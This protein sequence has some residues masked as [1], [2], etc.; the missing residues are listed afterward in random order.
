MKVGQEV[1]GLK[2]KPG[3]VLRYS[4]K[5]LEFSISGHKREGCHL[6]QFSPLFQCQ[7]SRVT[8]NVKQLC[9]CIQG[10]ESFG[11]QLQFLKQRC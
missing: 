7:L 1:V 10:L 5:V 9:N 11:Q 3:S 6:T 2:H 8:L 4:R